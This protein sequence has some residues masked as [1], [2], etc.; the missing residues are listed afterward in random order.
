MALS[1]SLNVF[2]PP[3][4]RKKNKIRTQINQQHVRL[5][6]VEIKWWGSGCES[7]T[8]KSLIKCKILI[9]CL[10]SFFFFPWSFFPILYFLFLFIMSMDALERNGFPLQLDCIP[11]AVPHRLKNE[12]HVPIYIYL[13]LW[14]GFLLVLPFFYAQICLTKSS[15]VGANGGEKNISIIKKRWW[16]PLKKRK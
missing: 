12:H 6:I 13:Y 5:K 14:D 11:R 9:L 7:E 1:M 2:V 16:L 15:N 10:W 8:Y 3:C 4:R